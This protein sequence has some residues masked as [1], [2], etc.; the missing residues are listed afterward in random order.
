MADAVLA[1]KNLDV[2]FTTPDGEVH[3]VKAVNFEVGEG[4]VVGVVGESG[5]GKSQLFLGAVGLLA[6]NGKATGSVSY[7]GQELIGA[8]ESRLNHIRGSK[9]TMIFQDPLTSLTPH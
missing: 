5:S 9:V 2:R 1:V 6:G 3:A 8:S 7:R 4:E